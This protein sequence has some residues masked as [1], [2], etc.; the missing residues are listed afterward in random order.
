VGPHAVQSDSQTMY[1]RYEAESGRWTW[2][3]GLRRLHG[4]PIDRDPTTELMLERMVE[5]DRPET[6]ARFEHHLREPGPYSCV[7][8]MRDPAGRLRRLIF[9][10]Q[11]EATNGTVEQLSGFVVDLTEP[12]RDSARAAVAASVEHRAA[13]EQAKG[14]LMLS[15]G[16]E[17][18]SAF[19][20]LRA[21]SSQ[22]N[23]K[24]AVVA[25]RI[26]AGLS[27]PGFSRAEPVRSLLDIVIGLGAVDGRPVEAG[28]LLGAPGDRVRA[29]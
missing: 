24:L 18:E 7:Y 14:A 19:D 17:E 27:D 4:L 2:S 13:I 15:F 28:A 10:G 16:I 12:L 29:H 1:F 26:V 8:R 21:Y 5:E 3:A 25:E 6:V 11:S 23:V 9:V 22:H 20:L